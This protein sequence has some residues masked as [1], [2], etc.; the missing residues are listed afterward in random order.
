MNSR[1]ST[2]PDER[3]LYQVHFPAWAGG[4]GS[5]VPGV[6]LV[7]A[8]FMPCRAYAQE[9]V[10]INPYDYLSPTERL[11]WLARIDLPCRSRACVV[12][13]RL[14]SVLVVSNTEGLPVL[15]KAYMRQADGTPGR[16]YV[17]ELDGPAIV[18]LIALDAWAPHRVDPIFANDSAT[19]DYIWSLLADIESAVE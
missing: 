6:F 3:L 17:A 9:T 11:T 14:D 19:F 12:R 10:A 15:M 8:I 13:V 1:N 16:V 5:L 18:S 4:G 2:P 7:L